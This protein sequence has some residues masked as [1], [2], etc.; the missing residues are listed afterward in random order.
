M[1]FLDIDNNGYTWAGDSI[2]NSSITD[3]GNDLIR[4]GISDNNF[5]LILEYKSLKAV[6]FDLR[7]TLVKTIFTLLRT[8][9]I[10]AS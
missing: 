3:L 5:N 6:F 9:P 8:S 4:V 7:N 2:T 10:K 1:V